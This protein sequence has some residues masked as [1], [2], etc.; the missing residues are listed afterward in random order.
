MAG[1]ITRVAH[2]R[3]PRRDKAAGTAC[4]ALAPSPRTGAHQL[5]RPYRELA[6][7]YRGRS[8]RRDGWDRGRQALRGRTV[9]LVG[10]TGRHHR[11]ASRGCRPGR[12][13]DAGAHD[14]PPPRASGVTTALAHGRVTTGASRRVIGSGAPSAVFRPPPKRGRRRTSAGV[15][16]RV[17]RRGRRSPGE[18]VCPLTCAR[19]GAQDR[20]H[21]EH[22]LLATPGRDGEPSVGRGTLGVS[23]QPCRRTPLENTML[24]TPVQRRRPAGHRPACHLPTPCA[25]GPP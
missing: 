1:T 12:R 18:P 23:P 22:P 15:Q 21:R 20:L 14:A 7:R 4:P 17:Q 16:R 19:T 10:R 3:D 9:I 6:R 5:P 11:G 2:A 8:R 24:G 25:P 13:P